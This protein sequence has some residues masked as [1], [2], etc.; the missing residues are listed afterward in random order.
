MMMAK[1]AAKGGAPK[2][3]YVNADAVLSDVQAKDWA[4]D[5]EL[6]EEGTWKRAYL[7]KS[8]LLKT[9]IVQAQWFQNFIIVCICLAGL[10]VGLMVG[11]TTYED[12]L[13]LK[14]FDQIISVIFLFEVLVK[15]GSEG[16]APWRFFL[17]PEWMWNSFDLAICVAGYA[18]EFASSG[19][20]SSIKLLRLIRLMRVSK[21]INRVPQLQVIIFGLAGGIQSIGY[22]LLLMFLLFFMFSVFAVTQFTSD[23]FHFPD[24][25]TGMMTLLRCAT[26][27]DWTDV[28]YISYFGCAHFDSQY[29]TEEDWTPDNKLFWCTDSS[30][31]SP[32]QKVIVIIY[33]VGF[34]VMA[35]F[36]LLSLF[37]GAV[38]MSMAEAMEEQKHKKMLEDEQ[39]KLE[40]HLQRRRRLDDKFGPGNL[41]HP[42]LLSE[43]KH[44]SP[45][46][47]A[48]NRFSRLRA[49]GG[50]KG[51]VNIVIAMNRE[52][53]KQRSF[54]KRLYTKWRA[55]WKH[56][57][58]NEDDRRIVLSWMK[59]AFISGN[60]L[61]V[62]E[63]ENH[64]GGWEWYYFEVCIRA[65]PIR[66]S[67]W[68]DNLITSAI[69]VVAI[70]VGLQTDPEINAMVWVSVVSDIILTIFVLEVIIKLLSEGLRPLGFF[71]SWW[72]TFDFF[73][74]TVSVVFRGMDNSSI[75]PLLRM[76]R[77]L[78]ILRLLK[79]FPELAVLVNAMIV[80]LSSIG[81][82]AALL[83]LTF[84]IFAIVGIIMFRQNDPWHFS[85]LGLSMVS[86]FRCA[87]LEDWTDVMYI[88]YYGCDVWGYDD[89]P[90]RCT[91]SEGYGFAAFFYFMMFT[92]TAGFI[93][94]TLFVG[95]V[96]TSM[97]EASESMN[98]QR[99]RQDRLE[100]AMDKFGL[101]PVDLI[102][103]QKVFEYLDLDLDQVISTNDMM[104][105]LTSAQW[106]VHADEMDDWVAHVFEFLSENHYEF[107][108]PCFITL[109]HTLRLQREERDGLHETKSEF[110]HRTHTRRRNSIL[111]RRDGSAYKRHYK[112]MPSP[113]TPPPSYAP[114]CGSNGHGSP[115][116]I[117]FG[118]NEVK[119]DGAAGGPDPLQPMPDQ[120]PPPANP[121]R[122][123]PSVS[124]ISI[125]SNEPNSPIQPELSV[126]TVTSAGDTATPSVSPR[127]EPD[128]TELDSKAAN[129]LEPTTP[130]PSA[131]PPDCGGGGHGGG[132]S[133]GGGGGGGGESK[134]VGNGEGS[135]GGGVQDEAK[136][137]PIQK[138]RH[139]EDNP[140]TF[141]EGAQVSPKSVR[142]LPS[143][144][145]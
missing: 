9:E 97:D 28:M 10:L 88:N 110:I 72:N 16:F 80:G 113:R 53:R 40:Q 131:S 21:V 8:E 58:L 46:H 55:A 45:E 99:S 12:L 36:V 57:F 67:A 90:D 34:T 70:M 76:L 66:D 102:P 39:I 124:P 135:R 62:H 51:I 4:N 138:D 111:S 81:Y 79:A 117:S 5:P 109:V 136:D 98:I 56:L 133:S 22:I 24:V 73:I 137:R 69:C 74:V 96:T 112:V 84:Y 61:V 85:T 77:L 118:A 33:F 145:R 108:F 71:K 54:W 132:E 6:Y 1:L 106:D 30:K 17:T 105:G 41:K 139:D 13:V 120:C 2:L 93:E 29:V 140:R 100:V 128:S 68:F 14:I 26:G 59:T 83:T 32:L 3:K 107:D 119:D 130:A 65:K 47:L 78:R 25:F 89:F 27:E 116:C 82:I 125:S 19:G 48:A 103:Y 35:S 126:V 43:R 20:G 123:S 122:R 63:E 64:H 87:T 127:P 143:L 144:N 114:G 42:T 7:V 37:V 129:G 38:T 142:R 31:P 86:L 49:I 121:P 50:F 75:V 91:N 95:V 134:G 115:N 92:I 94:F 52:G 141:V 15:M 23:Q 11:Y 101:E 104:H 60:W 44:T 18:M